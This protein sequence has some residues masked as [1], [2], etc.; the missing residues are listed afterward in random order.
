MPGFQAALWMRFPKDD[1]KRHFD[2]DYDA[3]SAYSIG[4]KADTK[5]WKKDEGLQLVELS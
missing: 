4:L 1:D 5:A 3:T 2:S